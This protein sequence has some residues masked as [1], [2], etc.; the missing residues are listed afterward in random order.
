MDSSRPLVSVCMITYNQEKFIA[1][2][3]EGVLMQDVDFDVELLISDDAST[4][5]TSS[6][7]QKYIE[8]HPRGNWI[9]YTRHQKNK[10][11]MGNFVWSLE[12]C[13]GRYIALCEGDDYWIDKY[14]LSKQFNFLE[15]NPS[16]SLCTHFSNQIN[17]NKEINLIGKFQK[18]EF[19]VKDTE[20]SNIRF[21]TASLFFRNYEQVPGFFLKVYG[22][23]YALIY[24]L[25]LNGNIKVLDFIGSV[26]RI[27]EGGIEQLY[28]KDKF[29]LPIRNIKEYKVYRELVSRDVAWVWT[30]RIS[31]NYF[32]LSIQ[33]FL[34][35][36]I[37][38]SAQLL[39]L[40]FKF[41]SLFL[42]E[43]IN[44]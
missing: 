20:V 26:Y 25:S 40:F 10:G 3:I 42:F 16:F 15:N 31:W 13:K 12:N 43:K 5:N 44:S 2:A 4:D 41:Y 27:H 14:K 30:K 21:P 17:I 32:Y 11:M 28:K 29:K 8:N 39:F 18:T 9:K 22:G 33:Y 6:I 19:T 24:F 36:K 38:K 35:L 34:S 7:I 23:D 37:F 1:E